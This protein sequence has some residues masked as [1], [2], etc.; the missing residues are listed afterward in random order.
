MQNGGDAKHVVGQIKIPIGFQIGRCGQTGA[1]AI[2]V[3]VIVFSGDA[4]RLHI[5]ATNASEGAGR[6]VPRHAVVAEVSQ[7]VAN[8]GEFPIEHRQHTRLTCV[9]HEV[10]QPIVAMHDADFAFIACARW[11]VVGQPCHQLVH[12]SNGLRDRRHI[13]FAPATN[14]TLEIIAGATIV[15]Q[16]PLCKRHGVQ[17]CDHAV[18]GVVNVGPLRV[19]HIGQG[20]FPQHATLHK[21]HDIKRATDDAL[22]F[23]QHMHLRDRH[24]GAKQTT[25]HFELAFNRVG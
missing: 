7:G 11:H 1:I 12:L 16:A 8:G 20:L 22:V 23:A 3:D 2:T 14:L 24:I 4:Q 5:H 21:L 17:G 13:L 10:V 25:H 15:C 9:E 6:N 18:H 19:G